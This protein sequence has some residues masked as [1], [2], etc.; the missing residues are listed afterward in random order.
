METV[1]T[2]PA[3]AVVEQPVGGDDDGGAGGGFVQRLGLVGGL[4][5]FVLILLLP[6]PSGLSPEA[7]RTAAVAV[8]MASWWLTEAAPI[9]VTALLPLV[10]FPILGIASMSAAAAP[11][12]NELIFLFMGGFFLAAAMQRW[13]VHR[14]IAL[15]IMASVGTSPKSLLL[16]IMVATAFISMWI[17]NTATAAMMLPIALAIAEM[18]RPTG[19]SDGK[20][21]AFG[22]AL[23][24]GLAYAASIGGVGTIVGTPPNALFAAAALELQ[25]VE[26]GFAQWMAVGIPV[27]LVLLPLTWLIL[28]WIYPPG[29]LRGDA[30]EV[31]RNEHRTQGPMS[32]GA[33]FVAGVFA[34]TVAAWILRAPKD[35]G[36]FTIP[37]LATWLPGITDSSIAMGAA[38]LL[39]VVPLDWKRGTVALD[40]QS[41]TRIQWGVLLLFGG[42]LSLANA[43]DQSGLANWVGAGVESLAGMP[44]FLL[45]VAVC[46]LFVFSGELTSNTAVTAMAM[47][48]MAG[49]GFALGISPITLMATTALACSMGF[50][51]PAGT[52]PNAIV[53]GSGYLTIAQMARAGI[54]V[55]II[56]I[57]LVALAGVFL[58]PAIF[59]G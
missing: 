14:R 33:K 36:A 38:L 31:L 57:L 41:A 22:I 51:L 44:M 48:V 59:G 4:A 55:N 18:L 15:A 17:S 12:A 2:R 11:Y 1:Q 23:M 7:W 45:L 13:A 27:T 5:L 43:M 46:A 8:L 26:I 28:V 10:L 32:R 30:T 58:I 9:P 34:I 25:G 53:F 35:L 29:N 40:W 21:Y 49:A 47:P 24:L 52:P 54:V 20:P 42:G 3:R 56:A 39:L 19:E 50:M 6:A 16:G 37:G